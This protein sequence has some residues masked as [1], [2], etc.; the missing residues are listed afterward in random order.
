MA[1]ANAATARVQELTPNCVAIGGSGENSA[2]SRAWHICGAKAATKGTGVALEDG[3]FSA[4]AD[5]G[6]R[7]DLPVEI[8]CDRLSSFLRDTLT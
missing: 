3:D 8:D 1:N 6:A 2:V 7:I 4:I 5:V